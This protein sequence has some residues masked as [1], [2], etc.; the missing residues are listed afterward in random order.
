M[1]LLLS[2]AR[3]AF[4]LETSDDRL[5]KHRNLMVVQ[6]TEMFRTVIGKSPSIPLETKSSQFPRLT[7]RNTYN[8]IRLVPTSME[9]LHELWI[10]CVALL[11]V[12]QI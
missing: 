5:R 3:L 9:E 4:F 8:K 7:L 6:S 11:L 10:I 1:K 12:V 2:Q